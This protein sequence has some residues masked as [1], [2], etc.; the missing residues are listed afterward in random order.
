MRTRDKALPTLEGLPENS[1]GVPPAT[2]RLPWRGSDEQLLELVRSGAPQAGRLLYDRFSGDVHRLVWRV[3]GADIE[4][5]DIVQAAFT[6]IF[7]AVSSVREAERLR[8]FIVAI[9]V[10][11]AR[12]ELR[13]RRVWFKFN[14]RD[15]VPNGSEWVH[16]DDHEAR[17]LVER[18]YAVLE[19]LSADERVTFVLRFMEEHKVAEVAELCG[20]SLATANRRIARA[21]RRFR[22]FADKDPTLSERLRQS[23]RWGE[24]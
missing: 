13:R 9:A 14:A 15:E 24:V 6:Q 7:R 12:S 3:L 21:E 16:I 22:F 20:C 18:T 4:H 2:A 5:D 23:P 8:S 17:I 19:R 10:N 1:G 11:V